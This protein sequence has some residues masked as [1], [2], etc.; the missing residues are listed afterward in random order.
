VGLAPFAQWLN[1][2][3][4]PEAQFVRTA[5]DYR[6]ELY[7]AGLAHNDIIWSVAWQYHQT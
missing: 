1:L 2:L 7:H 5:H 6:N 3:D 4:V